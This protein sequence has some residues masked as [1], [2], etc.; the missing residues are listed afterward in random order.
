MTMNTNNKRIPIVQT[1]VAGAAA[2]TLTW[3]CS[4]GFVDSTKVA[5]WVNAGQTAVATVAV[6]TGRAAAGSLKSS[7]LQ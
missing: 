4:W 3:V 6:D 1:L 7:L 5:R 2:L